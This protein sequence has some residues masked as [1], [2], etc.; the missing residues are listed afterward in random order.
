M[1]DRRALAAEPLGERRDA[2]ILRPRRRIL[3]DRR[4]LH[5]RPSLEQP[6]TGW[7]VEVAG[8]LTGDAVL[9]VGSD[10]GVPQHHAVGNG[11]VDPRRDR[12]VAIGRE[13][14]VDARLAPVD[15]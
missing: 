2:I 13:H 3:R 4:D 8:M 10:V 7:Q 15:H 5:Q 1:Q 14:R 11:R 9:G 6:A 12:V